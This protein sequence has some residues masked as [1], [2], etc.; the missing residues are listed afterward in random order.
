MQSRSVVVAKPHLCHWPLDGSHRAHLG[1]A[2]PWLA[3]R[4][5]GPPSLYPLPLYLP[6]AGSALHLG[7]R[8][9]H[10][11]GLLL[12]GGALLGK[13]LRGLLAGHTA[14]VAGRARPRYHVQHGDDRAWLCLWLLAG[15]LGG[16]H[17]EGRWR[18]ALLGSLKARGR[19]RDLQQGCL[20]GEL[21]GRGR[22]QQRVVGVQGAIALLLPVTLGLG[23]PQLAPPILCGDRREMSQRQRTGAS[24]GSVAR[25]PLPAPLPKTGPPPQPCPRNLGF[26]QSHL[27]PGPLPGSLA[28]S[29]GTL[30]VEFCPGPREPSG[31]APRG[32]LA[33]GTESS[34]R[35]VAGEGP[36][37]KVLPKG[38]GQ[39]QDTFSF[40]ISGFSLFLCLTHTACR[41][42]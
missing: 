41:I 2:R 17:I 27:Q 7:P 34:R 35:Q 30:A 23:Q 11:G 25:S 31:R 13:V 6:L 3:H 29:S 12:P 14:L 40:P 28:R 37:L 24:Q 5:G 32:V 33:R 36:T 10:G 22:W 19:S 38:R 4:G 26:G 1:Q 8:Q 39:K 21:G 16:H 9:L 18:E 20:L 42:F 15:G